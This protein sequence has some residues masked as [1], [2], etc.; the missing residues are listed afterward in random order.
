MVRNKN[1]GKPHYE[2]NG[3]LNNYKLLR[4]VVDKNLNRQEKRNNS[5]DKEYN[6]VTDSYTK[7]GTWSDR[8]GIIVNVVMV[9]F[10]LLLFNQAVKQNSIAEKNI[11]LADSVF[12]LSK[13]QFDSSVAYSKE[14]SEK[15]TQSFDLQRKSVN[16]QI[17]S[18][19]KTQ[20]TSK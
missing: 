2:A 10:T 17:A 15:A 13:R 14:A 12:N 1:T 5:K 16:T 19:S 7:Y 20:K 4:P 18:V 9:V 8:I 6:V 11:A 3:K